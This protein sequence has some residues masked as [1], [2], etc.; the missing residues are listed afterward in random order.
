[1]MSLAQHFALIG[2]DLVK[3]LKQRA[4]LIALLNQTGKEI[5][6][7][8][9]TQIKHFSANAFEL[10]TPTGNILA[11]S[12]SAIDVLKPTQ[13][14]TIEKYARIVPVNV[15][16]IERAGGSIRCMLAGIH[17]RPKTI[18]LGNNYPV[19]SRAF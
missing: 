4:S 17:L 1:M 15:P 14:M 12:Q 18:D 7:L 2:L 3:N 6:P 9:L 16:T 5:I 13:I 10:V 19:Q 11:I 8:S